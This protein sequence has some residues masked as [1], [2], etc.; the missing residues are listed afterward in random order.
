MYTYIHIY[1]YTHTYVYIH[2]YTYMCIC[3][4][5]HTHI[6]YTRICIY[7][8]TYIH[9]IS[10]MDVFWVVLDRSIRLTG[11]APNFLEPHVY[12]ILRLSGAAASQSRLPLWQRAPAKAKVALWAKGF[13]LVGAGLEV[14][15]CCFRTRGSVW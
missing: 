8:Y 14:R 15:D 1:I 9:H 2:I 11:E 4:Y 3:M 13:G 6:P 5:L 12:A 7:I 10:M